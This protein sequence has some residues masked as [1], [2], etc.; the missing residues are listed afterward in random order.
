M[1][2]AQTKERGVPGRT[3][4]ER[5]N[6]VEG[7]GA[8]TADD[9]SD[10]VDADGKDGLVGPA[11]FTATTPTIPE[12]MEEVDIGFEE[13]VIGTAVD[14]ASPKLH[15]ETSEAS[16]ARKDTSQGEG[17][18]ISTSPASDSLSAGRAG[19][20]RP[21]TP[22]AGH[23]PP[24]P[25]IS[26]TPQ[27]LSPSRYRP[28]GLRQSSAFG[29]T[30]ESL[31]EP[32]STPPSAS[33][34]RPSFHSDADTS[35]VTPSHR[36]HSPPGSSS[37]PSPIGDGVD[38]SSSNKSSTD[39]SPR[40]KEWEATNGSN[41]NPNTPR[42]LS[43]SLDSSTSP[44]FKSISPR[45]PQLAQTFRSPPNS[46]HSGQ[47]SF[48]NTPR[49]HLCTPSFS[50]FSPGDIAPRSLPFK[51]ALPKA[52]LAFNGQANGKEGAAP[53]ESIDLETNPPVAP[54]AIPHSTAM[55]RFDASA[56][57]LIAAD[58]D[59]RE[60]SEDAKQVKRR[61][62]GGFATK[63]TPDGAGQNLAAPPDLDQ[64]R[65]HS[66]ADD[67]LSP[68]HI[69]TKCASIG[70]QHDSQNAEAG[71]S[72]PPR[73]HAPPAHPH[74]YPIPTSPI[75]TDRH[76]SL[77][78]QSDRAASLPSSKA[79]Q[80]SQTNGAPLHGLGVKGISTFEKV[81][82]HTRPSWLP[83]KDKGEDEAHY[84]QWEEVMAQAK[85]VE[86]AR[87]KIQDARRLDREK[88]LALSVPRWE[89]LL[90]SG[91][92]GSA[93][94]TAGRDHLSALTM[95]RRG[96]GS[97]NGTGASTPN[98]V[99]EGF[100]VSKVKSDLGLRRLWFEGVPS[101]LRGKAWHLAIGNPLALSKGTH[102]W[103]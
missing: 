77:S 10:D 33:S 86:V 100:S 72:T 65:R 97:A 45:S 48:S 49:L 16:D 103:P 6:V 90:G 5:S 46:P 68:P 102:I 69:S 62:W 26:I 55:G 34:S 82:S 42:L 24:K 35:P 18:P 3:D 93:T 50:T 76:D 54:E 60:N 13:G 64:D 71:P 47:T 75:R 27:P 23:G 12:D 32:D 11:I 81:I 70:N 99:S 38:A 52:S 51:P 36:H 53:F 37:E 87:R 41:P 85:E 59:D 92:G 29:S 84:R 58:G 83:P 19:N 9:L 101:H 40:L 66:S 95:S 44:A 43:G 30:S 15:D 78:V 56:N 88:K 39:P 74:P 31:H 28:Y 2:D 17:S 4:T 20:S 91:P 94:P 89:A 79:P 61:S 57:G 98:G 80:S 8:V 25:R 63:K 73:R 67:K 1:D 14:L 22:P 96:S 21:E 7:A